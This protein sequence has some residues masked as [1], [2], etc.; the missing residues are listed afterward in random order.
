MISP[1]LLRRY[2]FFGLFEDHQLQQIAMIAE[3]ESYGSGENIFLEGE[4]AIH[5]FFLLEGGVDL[6]YTVGAARKSALEQGI[7]V[8]EI[9]PGETFGISAV[10]EPHILTS[11]AR[12]NGPCRVIMVDAVALRA[13]FEKDKK[14]AYSL[15]LRAAKEA[16]NRLY[17]T[18]VQLA[19][20]W[21]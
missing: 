13:L 15:T 17:A 1:E 14:L 4:P 8:G 20:A 3:E 2:P 11:T 7:P 9:N 21:A 5:L 6:Y 10:I 18:R 16:I 12:A 19:A